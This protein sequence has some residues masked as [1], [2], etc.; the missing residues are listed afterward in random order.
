MNGANIGCAALSVKVGF[1][2]DETLS[3]LMSKGLFKNRIGKTDVQCESLAGYIH[4]L[5]INA[6]VSSRT[7][8]YIIVR[9]GI[10]G[11]G[12]AGLFCAKLLRD[13]GFD[14]VVFESRS[15]VGGLARSFEW[16][17]FSCDFAAHRLFTKDRLLLQQLVKIT[18]MIEHDRR[19]QIYFNRKWMKDPLDVIELIKCTEGSKLYKLIKSYLLRPRFLKPDSFRTFV[20]QRYGRQLYDYFFRPYTEK[21]F[22]ISGDD[23]AL[24]WAETKVRL[25]GPLDRFRQSTKTK[26]NRFY[27]PER[28]GYGEIAS[29][30]YREIQNSVLLNS[31]VTGVEAT[32]GKIA[33]IGYLNSG[34][35]KQM[36]VDLVISTLPLTLT[37]K[38]VGYSLSLDYRAV[39]AVYLLINKSH[40]S[41][42]HWI[43]FMDNE[44]VVNRLVE[45]KNMSPIDTPKDTTV[46]CAEVT[47]IDNDTIARTISSLAE[48]GLLAQED[49]IDS[50]VITEPFAY[51]IYTQGYEA[52]VAE[53]YSHISRYQNLFTVG[54]AAEFRHREVDDN[55]TSAQQVVTEILRKY[56]M[57]QSNSSE[58]TNAVGVD[59]PLSLNEGPLQ[60]NDTFSKIP[61]V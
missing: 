59:N 55:F 50:K 5:V 61:A 10:I 11:A 33:R 1:T 41:H 14:V 38:M 51:P 25:A 52:K 23:V 48:T 32:D 27:Y 15:Y 7:W 16:H 49:V 28:G 9:V 24:S 58:P 20:E 39:H 42:N 12:V 46:V 60:S 13:A 6:Q 8:S 2:I 22:G 18:P 4:F 30:I 26:F 53:A 45:F 57:P 47:C 21:L 44:V 40:L 29:T 3:V 43:Y 19:S 37:S 56:K 17:G 36:E 34:E 54:R 35:E 31:R